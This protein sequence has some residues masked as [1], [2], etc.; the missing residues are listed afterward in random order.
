MST[1]S[2]VAMFGSSIAAPLATPPMVKVSPSSVV[3]VA[4]VVLGTVSVVMIARAAAGPPFTARAAASAGMAG[5]IRSMGSGKPIRPVEQT[6][7]SSGE[8]PS[9]SAV[10][11]HISSASALPAAPVAALALP[12]FRTTAAARPPVADRCSRHTRTGGAVILLEVNTPA[13]V[14]GDPS[15]VATIA[16]SSAP[17]ALT[18]QAMPAATNPGTAVTLTGT[19]RSS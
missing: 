11:A 8:Q 9:A 16:R 1:A 5:V 19:A 6:R 10:R 15:A 7:T 18:P 14:T 4:M 13:A 12:L 2:I 3:P 17:E